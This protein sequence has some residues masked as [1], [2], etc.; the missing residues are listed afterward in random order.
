MKL[1]IFLLSV[2]GFTACQTAASKKNDK[3]SNNPDKAT[4]RIELRS[5]TSNV[6]KLTDTLFISES[7]CRGCSDEYTPRFEIS[8]SL[9]IIQLLK[10]E[11]FD[12][13]PPD[14]D[15][16]SYEKRILLLPG[17]TGI[18]TMKLYR[19][20]GTDTAAK[21]PVRVTSYSINVKN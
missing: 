6:V 8:D 13:N 11:T 10:I 17:K 18:T 1:F 12:N 19:F 14:T 16:G 7:A 2:I 5:D 4:A 21:K 3:E 20:E 15:G 9:D